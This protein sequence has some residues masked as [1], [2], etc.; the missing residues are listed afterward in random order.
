MRKRRKILLAIRDEYPYNPPQPTPP[1]PPP[2]AGTT[3]GEKVYNA[4][5]SMYGARE[6]DADVQAIQTWYYGSMVKDNW[7]ATSMSY[8]ANA[9]GVLNRI[10]GK[11]ENVN[12]MREA[13]ITAA[14]QG[15]GLYYDRDHLPA[16]IPPYCICFWLWS[17]TTMTAGSS[18]HVNLSVQ[19]N[20]D[21]TLACIGGNQ[22][23]MI[24]STIYAKSRLYA[25]YV[26]GD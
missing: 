26:I 11:N 1:S 16:T 10:G 20:G 23:D 5:V 17:G 7:C 6:W 2:A 14:G 25:I 19:D 9:A 4:F 21:G 8:M 12:S 22:S 13:C 15:L 3:N 18:K 24:R